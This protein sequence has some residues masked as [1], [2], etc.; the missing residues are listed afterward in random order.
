MAAPIAARQRTRGPVRGV[1]S[2]WP[3]EFPSLET[4]QSDHGRRPGPDSFLGAHYI[5]C[6]VDISDP[7]DSDLTTLW[8][9]RKRHNHRVIAMLV[10]IGALGAIMIAGAAG[11]GVSTGRWPVAILDAI[12]CG[13]ALIVM[14]AVA[15]PF[16]L[17]PGPVR[18]HVDKRGLEMS[19]S[20]NSSRSVR[21]SDPHLQIVLRALTGPGADPAGQYRCTFRGSGLAYDLPFPPDLVRRLLD[22]ARVA[23]ARV[24]LTENVYRISGPAAAPTL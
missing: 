14:F 23:G 18:V 8:A 9:E 16:F 6:G 15:V 1:L 3:F 13:I 2:S 20:D 24:Q 5:A 10:G 12:G 19:L 7:G 17:R 4:D 21:W 11:Y 22:S